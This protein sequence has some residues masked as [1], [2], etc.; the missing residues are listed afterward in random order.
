MCTPLVAS[1]VGSD[2]S[3]LELADEVEPK[4]ISN[5]FKG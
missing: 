5:I 1:R 3:F 4:L 2:F